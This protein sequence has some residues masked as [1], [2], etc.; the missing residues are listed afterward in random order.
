MIVIGGVAVVVV[1][2]I[3]IAFSN[4]HA[5]AAA[6][7]DEED[8]DPPTRSWTNRAG[9]YYVCSHTGCSKKVDPTIFGHD[10]CGRCRRSRWQDCPGAER[11][12]YDGPGGFAH[13][14]FESLLRPGV[15]T[16]CGEPPEEHPWVFDFL[17]G[18]RESGAE[19]GARPK[20]RRSDRRLGAVPQG[21]AP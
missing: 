6:V 3:F 20:P 21:P 16:V 14:Y 9:G 15:C 8:T 1:R 7:V 17:A 2:G 11:R 10:C 5:T 13:N 19:P 4:T 18:E 12:A